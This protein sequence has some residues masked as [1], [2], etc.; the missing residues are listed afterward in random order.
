[1]DVHSDS[2]F[3]KGH[4]GRTT[5]LALGLLCAFQSGCTLQQYREQA[6]RTAG[7]T[8]QAGQ[9][10]FVEDKRGF[11]LDYRRLPA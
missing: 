7:R 10:R 1:M 3:P 9:G 8:I 11:S 5:G 2:V 4:W 6:D